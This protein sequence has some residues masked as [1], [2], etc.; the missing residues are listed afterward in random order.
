M[1]VFLPP[2]VLAEAL[3]IEGNN[4]IEKA[5]PVDRLCLAG[6]RRITRLRLTLLS[7]CVVAGMVVHRCMHPEIFSPK[8]E[9]D[10]I[11][12]GIATEQS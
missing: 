8:D 4:P 1:Q 2:L 10:N 7:Y 3:M 5:G 9:E 11:S 12:V 6:Q